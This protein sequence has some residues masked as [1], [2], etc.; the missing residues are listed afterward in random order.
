[1]RTVGSRPYALQPF[2]VVCSYL[3]ARQQRMLDL[4]PEA[5]RPVS[6]GAPRGP[7]VRD[8]LVGPPPGRLPIRRSTAAAPGGG[9]PADPRRARRCASWR[10]ALNHAG[11]T[12]T[13]RSGG[14]RPRSSC[15]PSSSTASSATGS[16][17]MGPTTSAK[18]R[19]SSAR[20]STTSR[21]TTCRGPTPSAR[22]PVANVAV[23]HVAHDVELSCDMFGSMTVE[24]HE[25][26]DRL[27]RIVVLTNE[28]GQLRE[29]EEDEPAGDSAQRR[30]RPGGAVPAGGRVGRS[31][32]DRVRRADVRQP[33]QAVPRRR[34]NGRR[35]GAAPHGRP[36]RARPTGW[37]GR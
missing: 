25:L 30:R 20:S 27:E 33:L 32:Q 31:L 9:R 18:A 16:S 3:G 2:I 5:R 37:W 29:L 7:C 34:R 22:I 35:R 19:S 15:S 28:G 14:W 8:G 26:A 21:T 36:V 13:R 17:A 12:A 24:P 6:R 1:M 4:G 10:S 11:R 23:A